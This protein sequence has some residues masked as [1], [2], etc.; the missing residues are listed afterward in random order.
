M[1]CTA[2]RKRYI[3][4][5]LCFLLAVSFSVYCLFTTQLL[6]VIFSVA[7]L[8][9]SFILFFFCLV[10]PL[11]DILVNRTRLGK[12]YKIADEALAHHQT[13]EVVDLHCDALICSRNLLV[14]GDFGH[15]DLPRLVVGNVAVQVFTIP[16][17]T[18][19]REGVPW[20][21]TNFDALIFQVLAQRWPSYTWNSTLGRA[22]FCAKRLEWVEENAGGKFFILRTA[23]DLEAYL[24]KRSANASLTAGILGVE[25]LHCLEGKL[26]NLD[27]LFD[28]GI[29]LGGLV[30]LGGNEVGG[31]A[32]GRDS[33][34]LTSFGKSVIQRMEEKRILIDLA[35]ASTK[36]IDDVLNITTRPVVVSHSGF[37][38]VCDNERNLRDEHAQHI[39]AQ[40][41]VIGVGYFPWATGGKDVASILRTLRYGI[42]LVGVDHIALG[43][44]YDGA[45]ATPFDISGVA[46]ITDALMQ[47]GLS[48]KD[49]AKIMGG[50]A[51]RLFRETL[52]QS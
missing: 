22:R 41:G 23:G 26:E 27:M 46:L 10:P 5:A 47:E 33:G 8:V 4:G 39:T 50:N 7:V 48:Q 6:L 38:G 9:L 14:P 19:V 24:Q 1:G 20:I 2:G 16:T 34:G 17:K 18:P 29:R 36:L 44:D 21:P 28:A 49:I 25:G 45:V 43:S 42:E 13:L 11:F 52:P 37:A 32:H 40:G 31:A 51:L 15:V 3:G 12:P 35:H 30:H